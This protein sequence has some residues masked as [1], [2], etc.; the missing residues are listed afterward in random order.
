MTNKTMPFAPGVM[1]Q[2]R[3][4][5][6]LTQD[7]AGAGSSD[8]RSASAAFVSSDGSLVFEIKG[9]PVGVHVMRIHRRD[10]GAKVHC[11]VLFD[12]ERAFVEWVDSDPLRFT[13]PLVFQQARR[14]FAQLMAERAHH[15]AV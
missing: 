2:P 12:N 7:R 8:L 4:L 5:S 11:S 10:D 14:C 15:D 3:D 13:H 6:A 9:E 1:R